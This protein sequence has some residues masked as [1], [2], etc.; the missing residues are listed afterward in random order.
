MLSFEGKYT[1]MVM[2]DFNVET[3]SSVCDH[4]KN[5]GENLICVMICEYKILI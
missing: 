5:L 3:D 1:S 2:G 4:L